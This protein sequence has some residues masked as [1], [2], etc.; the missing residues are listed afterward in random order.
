MYR[1][2]QL[3]TPAS[4]LMNQVSDSCPE[5]QC[6][7]V[8][9]REFQFRDAMSTTPQKITFGELRASGVDTVLIYCRDHRCSHHV[10]VS[11]DR[12]PDHVRLSDIEPSFT[13]SASASAA[14][15]RG[16]TLRRRAWAPIELRAGT[17]TVLWGRNHSDQ[18]PGCPWAARRFEAENTPPGKPCA[19]NR[20]CRSK[21][22][23]T[24]G[25]APAFAKACMGAD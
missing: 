3:G 6:P 24:C 11:A 23:Q 7:E 16:R 15:R 4:K 8:Q 10:T 21:S 12:W 22:V 1:M 19:I 5:A 14:P 13:C 20:G 2:G 17:P 9:W 25:F 18:G